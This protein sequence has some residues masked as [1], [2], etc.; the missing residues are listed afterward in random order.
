ML[1]GADGTADTLLLAHRPVLFKSPGALDGRFVDARASEDLV[2]ALLKRE[3]AL[4]RPRLVG[5]QV[6]VRF[7]DVV[8][9]QRIASPAVNG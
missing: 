2:L 4:G 6:G 5:G 9:D 7:N 3:V 8:L 1:L